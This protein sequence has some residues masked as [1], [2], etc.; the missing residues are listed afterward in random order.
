M[1]VVKF[2]IKAEY[3][4]MRYE[5][6][7]EMILSAYRS[8]SNNEQDYKDNIKR[9]WGSNK[10]NIKALFPEESLFIAGEDYFIFYNSN[11][12]QK[13]EISLEVLILSEEEDIEIAITRI[14]KDIIK[15]VKKNRIHITLK[16]NHIYFYPFNSESGDIHSALYKIKA[17]L[18]SKFMQKFNKR[19]VLF[20]S[21]VCIFIILVKLK[22]LGTLGENGINESLIASGIFYLLTD[23]VTK[24]PVGF[25][26]QVE[27]I[28]N[29]IEFNSECT[30]TDEENEV[31]ELLE[32]PE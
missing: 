5:S 11:L 32:N 15:K 8:S 3:K 26:I 30:D 23:I 28:P 4:K 16:Y 12:R 19:D 13:D 29:I 2:S 6:I 14:K 27:N 22:G 31:L 21:I 7:E 9:K 20:N 24:I 10:T 17:S 25:D 18:K 1:Q